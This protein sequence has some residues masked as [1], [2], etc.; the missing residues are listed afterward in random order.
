MVL[1][2]SAIL[3][4]AN[5]QSLP[6]RTPLAVEEQRSAD[7]FTCSRAGRG[8]Q[9]CRVSRRSQWQATVKPPRIHR[10][11]DGGDESNVVAGLQ[12][13]RGREGACRAVAS[14]AQQGGQ[15]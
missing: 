15:V 10:H 9:G 2:I 1:I 5:P 14:A 6:S 8:M 7:G 11:Q 12:E 13:G 3:L 4:S